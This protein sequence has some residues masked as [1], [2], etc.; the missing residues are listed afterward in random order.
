MSKRFNIPFNTFVLFA[1]TIGMVH[2]ASGV[3]F[4]ADTYTVPQTA[5]VTLAWDPNDPAPDGY[6]I[7]QRKEGQSYDHSQP[8]WT[9]Q[10]TSGTL[11]NLDWDTAYFFVVRAYVGAS[12]SADS[13]EVSYFSQS[14]ETKTYS[15]AASAGDHGSIS[16]GGTAIVAEGSDQVFTISP[17]T[18]YHVEDVAVDGASV[19]AVSLYTFNQVTDNHSIEATFAID[20]HI[21][22]ASAA[23]HGSIIPAGMVKVNHGSSQQ[24]SFVASDGYHMEDVLV[25]GISMGALGTY[26]F[27]AVIADHEIRATF[28]Q[29]VLIA[30]QPPT[31]DAGPDQTV[32]ENRTVA[33][34]GNNSIDLDDGIAS[35]QWRQTQG[36]GVVL[37]TPDRPESAFTAPNVDSSGTSLV[38]ELAVT[39]Y[40]G[41]TTV[42]TCIINVTW[43]NVPPTADA[44]GEQSVSEGALA[45]LDA[46]NSVDPDDGI[47]E[48]HW[49]QLQGPTVALSESRSSKVSFNAPDAGPEGI[50]LTFQ[51]TVRDT[52]GLQDSDTCLVTVVWTN[53]PPLA[54]AGPDQR[55][56]V[57]EDV[58][59]DGS[60]SSDTDG[61]TIV[62]Y[63]WRQTDGVPVEL[64]DASADKPSFEAPDGTS[65]GGSLSFELTV[66]DSGGLLSKDTCQ[67]VVDSPVE[68][69]KDTTIPT[70]AVQNPVADSITQS[71]FRIDLSGLAWDD[72]G[73]EQV[74]WKNNRGGSGVAVGTTQWQANNLRLQYGTNVITITAID[75]SGNST[76]VSKTVVVSYRR[77]WRR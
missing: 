45:T 59:L 36:I 26:T 60:L 39:D 9:G 10:A 29:D 13:A 25:D 67:V 3:C 58:I 32:E 77:W 50:S 47:V 17:E 44:G 71:K 74:V 23:N 18:G 48:Y 11:Y 4:S 33:L 19:G 24:F 6:R 41:L 27:A 7:Y 8:C 38:F 53:T 16:P 20:S 66:K 57:G 73:V 64:S 61:D 65:E 15:I 5:E 56:S 68:P 55:V 28:S 34:N 75:A 22:S 51:L 37:S 70:L 72:Q 69:V 14:P 46:A 54:D 31:A 63:R 52:G 43:V 76:S 30:N 49:Q 62:S 40:N 2:F 12:E 21:L 1:L 35:Y 42:D